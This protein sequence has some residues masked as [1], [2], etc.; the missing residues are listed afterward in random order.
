MTPA[1]ACGVVMRSGRM[2][3]MRNDPATPHRV[4]LLAYEGLAVFE[5][6]VAC[7]VFGYDRPELRSPWYQFSI[8]ATR[9]GPVAT[10][11]PGLTIMAPHGLAPLKQADTIVV[12]PT[13]RVDQVDEAYLAALRKAHARGARLISLCTGAFV[14]AAAG[15]LDGRRATTHWRSTDRLAADYPSI[16]VDPKVLY[17]DEGDVL[18]SAGSAASIDLCLHVVRNDFGSE[19]ASRLARRL[20]VPPH[21]DG[22]QAQYIETPVADVADDDGF[23]DTLSWLQ[24]HLGEQITIED[25]ARRSAMSPRTFARRFRSSTGTTPYKWILGQRLALA[26]RLLETRDWSID[27]VASTSGFGS[28]TNLRTQF[29]RSNGIAPQTYRKMFRSTAASSR[30]EEPAV[31][32][33]V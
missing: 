19:I 30:S 31:P 20:V 14:L 6:S 27:L 22:G 21:R 33:A 16:S 8:C 18:T 3:C 4:A 23:A 7:E 15:L 32:T 12:P 9:P 2:D 17:I 26:Q 1:C 11:T 5:F 29:V 10:G 25:L 24:E 13:E 28:A